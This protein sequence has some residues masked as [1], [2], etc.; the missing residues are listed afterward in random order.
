MPNPNVRILLRTFGLT[1]RRAHQLSSFFVIADCEFKPVH[2][3][4]ASPNLGVATVFYF[5]LR[6]LSWCLRCG[7][8][9]VWVRFRSRS[10]TVPC[11][12]LPHTAP[13][14]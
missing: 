13:T 11:L 1:K 3:L 4:E 12:G 6:L 5:V 7:R 8:L 10:G 9:L 2:P 14:T